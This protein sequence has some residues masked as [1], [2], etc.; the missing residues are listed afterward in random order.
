M[1]KFSKTNYIGNDSS[2]SCKIG[3]IFQIDKPNFIYLG[4]IFEDIPELDH[5][6]LVRTSNPYVFTL[7]SESGV[8]V[9]FSARYSVPLQDSQVRIRFSNK[10]SAFAYLTNVV[11]HSLALGGVSSKLYKYWHSQN[12]IKNVRK[13]CLVNTL[14]EVEGGKLLFSKCSKTSV[15]LSH[16][17]GL[18]I[19]TLDG[20]IDAKVSITGTASSI[21]TIDIKSTSQPIVKMVR[22]YKGSV[23]PRFRF[24]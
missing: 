20:L 10:H 21:G 18:K 12:Y 22:L 3:D 6:K 24:I 1:I 23:G 16:S 13:Y 14:F 7:T 5:N 2:L 9:D 8:S 11:T 15:T 19:D 4:N 17:Q